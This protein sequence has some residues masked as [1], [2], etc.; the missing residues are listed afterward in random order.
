MP[1]SSDASRKVLVVDDDTDFLALMRTWLGGEGFEVITAESGAQALSKLAA[2]QPR[3]VVTDLLMEG[4]SGLDL[5]SEIHKENPL[6]PV[7]MLSGQAQIPDAVKAMHLG[8]AAFLTKPVDRGELVASVSRALDLSPDAARSE[9]IVSRAMVYQ[10]AAMN[11]VVELAWLVAKSDVTVFISGATGTGKEV[12]AR[13]IHEASARCD[14]PFIA[15]NCAAIPEQLLE[16]ELFG[17]EKGAFTGANTRY[18]GLFKAADGGTLFLDE[19][20]DMPPALQVKLL[21]VL[22]EFAVRPVGSTRATPINVRVISATHR[23][24]DQAVEK[25]EFRADL[26]YRLKVVPMHMPALSERREDIPLLTNHFLQRFA[27]RNNSPIKSFAPQAMDFLVA[28]PWPGNIR[29][30]NNV[31]DLCATLC[32]TRNIPLS[33]ARTALQDRPGKL[34]TLKEARNAFE[35]NYL[36]TVLR[37]AN[38]RV[39]DAARMAGRN[40][41]EFYKLLSQHDI[42]PADF[43]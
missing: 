42:D 15:V 3:V 38:G 12:M 33:L 30:L 39:S 32:R 5:L 16:S 34:Q 4:M 18:E 26:Y 43:R 28:A 19:I 23:D 21:R 6:L 35:R 27:Q 37:I 10:S 11:E 20:G 8:S 2:S 31:V 7:I 9:Q 29:H 22:E 36:V 17:H 24:L 13:A 1:K 40:R 41:T 14:A 25:G